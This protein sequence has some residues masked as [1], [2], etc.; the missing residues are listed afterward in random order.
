MVIN[1]LPAAPLAGGCVLRTILWRR[2]G[3]RVLGYILIGL[4]L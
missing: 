3:N 2:H 4:R 1:V